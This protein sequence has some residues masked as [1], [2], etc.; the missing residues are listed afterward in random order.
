MNEPTRAARCSCGQLALTARGDPVRV[1]ICHC[2]ACQ[3]RTGSVFGAQ[4]RF[5][6]EAVDIV[7]ASTAYA[8]PA[9]SGH[10]L[11]F[12][13]CPRCGSTVY[14]TNDGLPGFVGVAIGAF[15]DPDAFEPAHS[16]YER[17]RHAWVQVPAAAARA[18][19]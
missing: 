16:V 2:T 15:A 12:H 8:R 17:T 18:M 14:Y 6:A 13:F 3:R 5:A 9:D 11:T 19:D 1:S 10:V 4:V 7:G